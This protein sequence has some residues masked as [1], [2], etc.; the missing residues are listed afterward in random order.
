MQGGR[1]GQS[2][3]LVCCNCAP[4]DCLQRACVCHTMVPCMQLEWCWFWGHR[5]RR[6]L[7]AGH[8]QLSGATQ[9]PPCRELEVLP[10]QNYMH[11]PWQLP[12]PQPPVPR[13]RVWVVPAVA[14]L[15]HPPA[16]LWL[17]CHQTQR[18]LRL[19]PRHVAG[20][21]RAQTAPCR[22]GPAAEQQQQQHGH[23]TC[24]LLRKHMCLR[25]CTK[26]HPPVW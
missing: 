3:P 7:L 1:A 23:V 17:R 11:A 13:C 2:H 24:L 6:P 16:W 10:Y 25:R 18:R 12:L 20:L 21:Q 19:T 14:L 9:N 15:L 4:E 22:Q 26:S 5:R 8:T